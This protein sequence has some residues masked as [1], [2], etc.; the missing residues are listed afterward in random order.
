MG[1]R[2]KI[3]RFNNSIEHNYYFCGT[4][5]RKG[6]KRAKRQKATPDQIK[7]QNHTNKVN[8]IRRLIKANFYPNDYLVTLMY[9]AGTRKSIDEVKSDFSKFTR[10]M[11]REYKKRNEQ[12]KFIYRIEIGK[13]GGIHIH[14]IINRLWGSDLLLTKCWPNRYNLTP[15]YAKGDFK[16]LASYLAKPLPEEC[17]QMSFLDE[18]EVKKMVIINSSRNLVRPEPEIKDYKRRTVERLVREGP[19]AA[20]GYYIDQE[21]VEY[22]V[23]PYTGYSYIRYTEIRIRQVTRELKPPPGWRKDDS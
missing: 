17:E 7:R 6:E 9:P 13:L 10:S 19:K 15:L 8:N 12:F 21:S 16:Q 5:G 18:Q 22:G 4:Y 20:E 23:N 2:S 3:Y 14:I 11:R 1:H